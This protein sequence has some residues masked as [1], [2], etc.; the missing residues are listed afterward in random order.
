MRV[1]W[2]ELRGEGRGLL[3]KVS[4]LA[5]HDPLPGFLIDGSS[6]AALA[7]MARRCVNDAKCEGFEVRAFSIC[8]GAVETDLLRSVV[9]E[10]ACPPEYCLQPQNIGTLASACAKG[11]LDEHNGA[12]IYIRKDAAGEVQ[13]E[14]PSFLT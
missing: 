3:I 9:D 14:I 2:P 7:S 5:G 4:S 8:P 1:A 13:I 11:E 12:E 10:T 6:K